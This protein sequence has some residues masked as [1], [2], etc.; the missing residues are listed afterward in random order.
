MIRIDNIKL[1]VGHTEEDLKNRI[2]KLLKR[3]DYRFVR[4]LRRSLDARKKNDIHYNYSVLIEHD[5]NEEKTVKFINNKNVMLT[6]PKIY[7]FP[8]KKSSEDEDGSSI[9]NNA[10]VDIK[11]ALIDAGDRPVIIG[12]GPAGYFAATVLADNGFRP[13]VIERGRPVEE[14]KKDVET[15]WET[16]DLNEDSNVSFGEGGAGTFSDGKLNTG[17]KDKDGLFAYIFETFHKYGAPEAVTYEAKPHIGTDVLIDIMKNMR[18][19]ILDKGGNIL[20]DSKLVDIILQHDDS[21]ILEIEGKNGTF[22]IKA[23]NMILAIG[24]SSRD[25]FKMLY[26]RGFPME[27]KPFAIGLRIEHPRRMIDVDRYGEELADKLPAADYKLTYHAENGRAVFS[28]CMCPGG[29]VVNASSVKGHM[30][31]NGMSDSRRDSD[32]SNAAIVVSITPED[33]KGDEPLDAVSFQEA[34]ERS[35]FDAGE[36]LIPVQR[37]GDFAAGRKTTELG[38][39]KP[40]TKGKISLSELKSC[41][42]EYVSDAI[43]EGIRYF[44]TRIEGF[45]SED[46]IL[47]GIESRTSS[48]VRIIR[49]EKLQAEGFPGVF[50]CGEGAG[51]AGGITSAAADGIRCAERA[52][53]RILEGL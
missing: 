48:P 37:F 11:E 10:F 2:K 30:T 35:F 45:D 21:Y 7:S 43:I 4:I 31:V 13:I 19:N 14:R 38:A 51:Y 9:I 44:G 22:E 32:N 24:H 28:F 18:K 50:P 17:N 53:E 49:N 36:G 25:S 3:D 29:Y 23:K 6:K 33:I 39:V 41:L 20:F 5:K 52:A 34:L 46:A 1:P 12:S 15:F 26:D 8:F 47:S 16:G 42:P 40:V 27:Q